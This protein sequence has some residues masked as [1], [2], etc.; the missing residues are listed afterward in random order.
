MTAVGRFSTRPLY[1][2]VKDMLIQRIVSCAWKPGAAIPNEIELSRELGISVGTVRKALDEMEGE[3][4]I[5]RRQG[6]GTFVID[7]TSDECAVR[8]SNI[9]S[10][11][12]I[13]IS[14]EVKSCEVVPAAANATEARMLQLRNGES[15]LRL[16][17]V[18][19]Q[20]GHPLMV[21]ESTVPQS[22]FP[23][24]A[25]ETDIPPSIVVLA[26]HYGVL[27]AR[28]QER[29][30]VEAADS[31]VASVLNVAKGTPLLKLDSVVFSIDGLPIEW[32]VA[33]CNLRDNYYMTDIQ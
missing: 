8:F 17:R 9:H 12:Q 23:G 31:E 24:L 4:L 20:D 30:S 27:L 10:P 2:Q 32:R 33:R 13:R 19:Q 28:A 29:I 11:E 25:Q 5:S 1:L 21:E 7:Q 14:G 3:H 18:R 16:R 26:Q 15:V 6:R 22:R